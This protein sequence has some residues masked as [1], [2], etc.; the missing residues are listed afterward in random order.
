M[1][2]EFINK[3]SGK[4]SSNPLMNGSDNPYFPDKCLGSGCADWAIR[5]IRVFS[6]DFFG[7]LGI[8]PNYQRVAF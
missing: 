4:F 8:T 5:S 2:H 7:R 3:L 6:D 1:Q